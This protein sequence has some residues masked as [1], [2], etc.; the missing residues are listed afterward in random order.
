MENRAEGR[1]E[2]TRTARLESLPISH[3]KTLP[4]RVQEAPMAI[5]LGAVLQE[6]CRSVRSRAECC[7]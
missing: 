3:I 7:H 4:R 1:A 5:Y 6:S 2:G